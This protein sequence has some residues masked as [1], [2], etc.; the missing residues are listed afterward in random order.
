VCSVER[1]PGFAH[2]GAENID[3]VL[4]SFISFTDLIFFF[5]FL[6][7]HLMYILAMYTCLFF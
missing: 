2:E 1:P 6:K 4:Y 7:A 3:N 5:S